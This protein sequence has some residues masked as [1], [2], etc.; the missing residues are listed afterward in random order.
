MNV[1]LIHAILIISF[2]CSSS[3]YAE[4]SLSAEAVV[5]KMERAYAGVRDY[6]TKIEVD[7]YQKSGSV[8]T[9]KFLYTF[10]KPNHIRIDFETPHSGLTLIYPYKDGKAALRSSGSSHFWRYHPSIFSSLLE[11]P[12]GQRVDQTDFGLL[13]ENVAHSIADWRQ[14]PVQVTAI[15]GKIEISVLANDHFRK[16][17]V[18]MYRFSIDNKSWLPVGVEESSSDGKPERKVVFQNIETNLNTPDS[19]YKTDE[20]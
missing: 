11:S 10:K 9:Q 3:V 17:V 4:A 20:E 5:K 2:V 6:R 16:G 8:K 19:F 14:G 7:N 15:G 1:L 12:S 18:T 13:I